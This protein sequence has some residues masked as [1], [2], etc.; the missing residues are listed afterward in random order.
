MGGAQG[1]ENN[2]SVYALCILVWCVRIDQR[3][4]C[5]DKTTSMAVD[6]PNNGRSTNLCR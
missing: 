2:V 5:H 1:V 4:L 6:L 3:L